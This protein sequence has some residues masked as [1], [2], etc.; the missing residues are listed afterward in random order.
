MRRV[1]VTGGNKGIG[2]ALVRAILQSQQ[3]SF[4]LL[5]SR[6]RERGQAAIDQLLVGKPMP[7]ITELRWVWD[8][9]RPGYQGIFNGKYT[10]KQAAIEMQNLAEKLIR[11]NRE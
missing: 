3:D 2:F 6:S 9:M 1:L 5:G 8:A 7:V 11:E 4:V 10:P